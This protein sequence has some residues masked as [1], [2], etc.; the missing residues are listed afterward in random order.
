M[1]DSKN[2]SKKYEEQ[3]SISVHLKRQGKKGEE[4]SFFQKLLRDVSCR[5]EYVRN[6]ERKCAK[7]EKGSENELFLRSTHCVYKI[8]QFSINL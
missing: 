4:I 5:K 7:T 6:I 2:T 8:I 1:G 3:S